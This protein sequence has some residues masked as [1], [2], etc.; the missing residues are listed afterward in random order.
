MREFIEGAYENTRVGLLP[1][2]A[3]KIAA[4]AAWAGPNA[5]DAAVPAWEGVYVPL[6]MLSESACMLSSVDYSSRS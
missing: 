5:P 6:I 3:G 2:V 4:A 1:A